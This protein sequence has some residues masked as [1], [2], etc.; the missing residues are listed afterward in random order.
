MNPRT[1]CRKWAARLPGFH[2]DT[3]GADYSPSMS[4]TE[5]SEYDSD[6]EKLFKTAADPYDCAIRAMMR[7]YLTRHELPFAFVCALSMA[8]LDRAYSQPDG[9]E[10][11][12]RKHETWKA[13]F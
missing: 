5:I 10:Y 3:R 6:M 4:E 7:E 9:L 8:E 1:I 2:P 12:K 11:I 13:Q